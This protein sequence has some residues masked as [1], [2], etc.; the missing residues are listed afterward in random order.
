MTDARLPVTRGFARLTSD[1]AAPLGPGAAAASPLAP[2]VAVV[3]GG[4][5]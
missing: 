3:F 2:R 5:I 1:I 4:R